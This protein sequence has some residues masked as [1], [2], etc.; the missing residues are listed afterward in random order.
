MPLLTNDEIA[1]L[2]FTHEPSQ[3]DIGYFARGWF[4]AGAIEANIRAKAEIAELVKALRE[5][6]D[7]LGD[8]QSLALTRILKDIVT[9]A[10]KKYEK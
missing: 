2:A 6:D 7:Q 8:K 4:A 9:Y 10:L 3:D 5:I 1:K